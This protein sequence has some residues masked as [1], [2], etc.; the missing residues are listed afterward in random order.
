MDLVGACLEWGSGHACQCESAPSLLSGI[1]LQENARLSFQPECMGCAR[2]N[3][4]CQQSTVPEPAPVKTLTG[5]R[6]VK[7]NQ[8]AIQPTL[9]AHKLYEWFFATV[10]SLFWLVVTWGNTV[11]ARGAE[12]ELHSLL[13]K[14]LKWCLRWLLQFT[15]RKVGKMSF[16]TYF[17]SL[18]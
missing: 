17:S 2:W 16:R 1:Q 10:V 14:S 11:R 6:D 15:L 5:C 13:C 9:S 4:Q 7:R 12:S 8:P 18:S 3:H